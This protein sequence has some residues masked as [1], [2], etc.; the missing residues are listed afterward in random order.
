[1]AQVAAAIPTGGGEPK[2]AR[3]HFIR[4]LADIYYDVR[5]VEP[6]RRHDPVHVRDYGPFPDFVRA[7]LKPLDPGAL[8]G[9]EHEVRAV[10]A[11]W[12]KPK[13]KPV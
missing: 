5:G 8:K 11:V 1:V 4:A 9:V 13:P 7:A 3:H 10:L 12:Q 6:K 2:L